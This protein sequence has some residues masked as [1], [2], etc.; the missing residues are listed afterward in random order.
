MRKLIYMAF[1]MDPTCAEIASCLVDRDPYDLATIVDR[2]IRRAI[3]W[4]AWLRVSF[5]DMTFI[6]PWIPV[7]QSLCKADRQAYCSAVSVDVRAVVDRCAGMVLVGGSIH[8]YPVD[9]TAARC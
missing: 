6:A 4:L 7:V 8:A 3:R 9:T 1:P 2:N 5:A